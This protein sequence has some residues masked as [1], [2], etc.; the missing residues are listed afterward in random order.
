[1]RIHSRSIMAARR[2]YPANPAIPTTIRRIPAMPVMTTRR[3]KSLQAIPE[4]VLAQQI[5]PTA[6]NAIQAVQ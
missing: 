3:K 5:Y 6:R 2:M 4:Q 1:M